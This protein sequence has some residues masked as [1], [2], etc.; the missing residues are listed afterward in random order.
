[1]HA[2]VRAIFIK[3]RLSESEAILTSLQLA[4]VLV[5]L[6]HIASVIINADQLFPSPHCQIR[7]IAEMVRG[8]SRCGQDQK[9]D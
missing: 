9:L 8:I 4:L 7:R 1:M 6:D 3:D 5:C 2:L